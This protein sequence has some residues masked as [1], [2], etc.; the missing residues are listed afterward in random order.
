VSLL[1]KL[2][3]TPVLVEEEKQRTTLLDERFELQPAEAANRFLALVKSVHPRLLVTFKANLLLSEDSELAC[4]IDELPFELGS[5]EPV[6]FGQEPLMLS[7]CAQ[8]YM[9]RLPSF[10]EMDE[11]LGRAAAGTALIPEDSIERQWINMVLSWHQLGYA[12]I[13]LREE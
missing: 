6:I 4:G 3:L 7:H 2:W 1:S 9:D 11:W 13:L 5:G 8:A 10:K 12:V